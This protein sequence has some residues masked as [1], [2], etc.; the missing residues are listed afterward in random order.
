MTGGKVETIRGTPDADHVDKLPAEGPAVLAV[1]D[2]DERT[3]APELNELDGWEKDGKEPCESETA[4]VETFVRL[5]V[6]ELGELDD[7]NERNET[8]D[9]EADAEDIQGWSLL[10]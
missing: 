1:S 9:P 5:A 7:V 4:D 3:A 8:A 10:K 2:G 6:E